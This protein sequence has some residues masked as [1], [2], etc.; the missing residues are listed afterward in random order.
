MDT[1]CIHQPFMWTK[2]WGACMWGKRSHSLAWM[3]TRHEASA[4]IRGCGKCCEGSQGSGLCGWTGSGG[5]AVESESNLSVYRRIPPVLGDHERS[6]Q[7]I[8]LTQ[9]LAF[10][11]SF[12]DINIAPATSSAKF[13]LVFFWVYFLIQ[14]L[15]GK[16]G[17]PHWHLLHQTCLLQNFSPRE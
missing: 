15:N 8:A 17:F 3:C 16:Q 1:I 10:G 4:R 7:L 11:Y 13:S 6:H 5:G 9:I 14:W 2:M 12:L